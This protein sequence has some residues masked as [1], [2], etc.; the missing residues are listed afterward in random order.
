VAL[1]PQRLPS[2]DN[3]SLRVLSEAATAGAEPDRTN[4]SFDS[5]YAPSSQYPSHDLPNQAARSQSDAAYS[6]AGNYASTVM[7]TPGSTNQQGLS[8]NDASAYA[9][10]L[11]PSFAKQSGGPEWTQGLD[12]EQAIDVALSGLDFSGDLYT[13]FF[14]DGAD[15]FQIPA[16]AA[17]NGGRW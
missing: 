1:P 14:G 11:D 9:N 2:R 5:P 7:S 4:W 15:A 13:S 3:D 12:F 10:M 8:A 17:A 16:D 6:N